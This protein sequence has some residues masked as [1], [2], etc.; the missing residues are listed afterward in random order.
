MRFLL[1]FLVLINL[2]ACQT[3]SEI[4]IMV[5]E[6]VQVKGDT[7]IVTS[8][9][10]TDQ[11]LGHYK[12]SQKTAV[13]EQEF[14]AKISPIIGQYSEIRP[15][16]PGKIQ[17]ISVVLG[18]KVQKGQLLFSM[19]VQEIFELQEQFNKAEKD[20]SLAKIQFERQQQLFKHGIISQQEF[21]DAHH[22][23]QIYQQAYDQILATLKLWNFQTK[24]LKIGQALPI[25]SPIN[26]TLLKTN[27]APGT[28][29]QD[30]DQSWMVIGNTAE[31]WAVLLLQPQEIKGL[32]VAQEVSVWNETIEEWMPGTVSY[33]SSFIDEEHRHIE[34]YILINNASD[35]FKL[36]AVTQVRIP[37]N[38]G[39]KGW[40]IPATSVM[41]KEQTFVFV[42]KGAHHYIPQEVKIITLDPYQ[43]LVTEGLE[44]GDEI[45]STGGIYLLEYL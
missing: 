5:Q 36:G 11:S 10:P 22:S 17:N 42:K 31:V 12:I 1:F 27:L 19:Q 43:V 40:I 3:S 32:S 6:E 9:S 34:V 8:Q 4:E 2:W 45:I 26:G 25:L 39:K 41:Q 18:Q 20:W 15:P 30:P 14:T 21:E 16:F 35:Y 33:I 44:E 13:K 23:Y 28:W 7:L 29:I 38:Y 24:D 37:Q